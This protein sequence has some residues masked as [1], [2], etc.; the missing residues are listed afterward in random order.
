MK[1]LHLFMLDVTEL[2]HKSIHQADNLS[3]TV[4]RLRVYQHIN[5]LIKF[6]IWAIHRYFGMSRRLEYA[7]TVHSSV[8]ITL[9]MHDNASFCCLIMYSFHNRDM[10]VWIFE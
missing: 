8:E 9:P 2:S 4:I 6:C 3:A 5:I 10:F 7:K 1:Q